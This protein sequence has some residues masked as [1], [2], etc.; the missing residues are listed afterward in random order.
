MSHE[1]LQ[2]SKSLTQPW[3]DFLH[4]FAGASFFGAGV[5]DGGGVE[6]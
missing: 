5:V 1:L 4:W 3:S 2:Q 6:P